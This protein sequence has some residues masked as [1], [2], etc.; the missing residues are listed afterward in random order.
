MHICQFRDAD[1]AYYFL[2]GLS[3]AVIKRFLEIEIDILHFYWSPV[4]KENAN[5]KFYNA[6]RG[7]L[8]CSGLVLIYFKFIPTVPVP[9]SA[10]TQCQPL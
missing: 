6:R 3:K 1:H 4:L 9:F 10:H 2:L 7:P 8:Q 5:I